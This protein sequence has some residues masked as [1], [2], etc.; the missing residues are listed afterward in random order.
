MLPAELNIYTLVLPMKYA[1][2]AFKLPLA[3]G[4]VYL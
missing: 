3:Y 4:G 1:M 2:N